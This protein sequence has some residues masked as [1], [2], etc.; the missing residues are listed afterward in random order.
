M[1][2]RFRLWNNPVRN[3]HPVYVPSGADLRLPAEG[4]VIDVA[5]AL[6]RAGA[7]ACLVA[8]GAGE[9]AAQ[10]K[11]LVRRRG[12]RAMPEAGPAAG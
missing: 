6:L 3:G 7:D 8:P 1:A 12:P 5:V 4:D 11:A 10:I 2:I 9:V